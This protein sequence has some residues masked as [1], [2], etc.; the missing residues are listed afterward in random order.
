[1][2]ID[3][4]EEKKKVNVHESDMLKYCNELRKCSFDEIKLYIIN[5]VSSAIQTC[6]CQKRFYTHDPS[7]YLY[8]LVNA[9]V[10]SQKQTCWWSRQKKCNKGYINVH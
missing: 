7:R 5:L 8:Y 9:P 1:M 10:H 6:V 4:K 3:D 2:S